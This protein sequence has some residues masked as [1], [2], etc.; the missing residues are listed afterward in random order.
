MERTYDI[1]IT[2]VN[3]NIVAFWDKLDEATMTTILRTIVPTRGH[4]LHVRI[5]LPGE[6]K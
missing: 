5:Y 4:Y 1:E 2:D 6:R 3:D